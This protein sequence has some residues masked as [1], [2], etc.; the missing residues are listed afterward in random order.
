ME[1]PEEFEELYKKISQILQMS[2]RKIFGIW[3][4]FIKILSC[5]KASEKFETSIKKLY[6]TSRKV[7]GTFKK[8]L[9]IL[10]VSKRKIFGVLE[11]KIK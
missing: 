5:L 4:K 6:G 2:S 8:V 9:E 10:Q 7:S 3:K 1:T 11:K